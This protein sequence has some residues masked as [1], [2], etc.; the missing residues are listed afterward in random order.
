MA[1]RRVCTFRLADLHVGIDIDRVRE[2]LAAPAVTPVPLAPPAVSG[3]INLRGQIL[4]VVDARAR[5]SLPPASA[6]RSTHVIV[7]LA[8]EVVSVVVDT[9]DEVVDVVNDG[10]EPVPT[11]VGE[12]IRRCASGSYQRSSGLLVVLD[13]DILLANP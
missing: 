6:D 12:S 13:V 5:L 11:T 2:V 8:G 4:T 7:E 9:E 3:L 10:L 1:D